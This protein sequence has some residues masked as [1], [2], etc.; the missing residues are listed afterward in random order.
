MNYHKTLIEQKSGN[1]ARLKKQLPA[2]CCEFLDS[3]YQNGNIET[4]ETYA[5]NLKTFYDFLSENKN[6]FKGKTLDDARP[7]D[8]Q[9]VTER[10]IYVFLS[11]LSSY[12]ASGRAKI[13][14]SR[15]SKRHKLVVIRQ[16]YRFLAT[17][18]SVINE[19]LM[20]IK[21]SELL[22]KKTEEQKP[23]RAEHIATA[24]ADFRANMTARQQE[25]DNH[26]NLRDYLICSL[27]F[28][29]KLTAP[30]IAGIDIKDID[31]TTNSLYISKKD[32]RQEKRTL[33]ALTIEAYQKYISDDNADSGRGNFQP[34]GTD[35]LFIS[36][37]THDRLAS[38]T[39]L[40]TV[41]KYSR[42]L[43][44]QNG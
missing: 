36:R 31:T 43:E 5:E 8:F 40:F 9:L 22:P 2:C 41:R 4:I 17:R 29:E 37:K 14:N 32:G 35:A 7:S 16:F 12:S 15:E 26:L 23:K 39:I 30:E 13:S 11:Y 38:R 20:H 27:Y 44:E 6:A 28:K 25:I 10:D 1:I 42:L 21:S 33:D 3:K 18:Y 24:G 19:P 34:E